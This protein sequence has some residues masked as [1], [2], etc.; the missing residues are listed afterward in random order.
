MLD[1]FLEVLLGNIPESCLAGIYFK[2]SGQK[3]WDSPLDYVPEI[4]DI[5]IHLLLSD[6]AMVRQHLGTVEQALAIQGEV[7][8]RYFRKIA[9]ELGFLYIASGPLVRSSYRAGEFYLEGIT[10]SN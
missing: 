8:E 3:Q 5:D 2:G 10:R 4:S 7:E 6:D 9:E 1:A